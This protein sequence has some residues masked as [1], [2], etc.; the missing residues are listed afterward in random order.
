M[1]IIKASRGRITGHFGDKNVPGANVPSHLG[2]DL[3]HGDGTDDDLRI[4]AP[5]DGIV[6]AAGP[7]GSYGNRIIIDHGEGWTSLLAH[8][9]RILVAVGAKVTRGDLRRA[10]DQIAVMGSTGGNWAVHCHQELRFNGVPVNPEDYLTTTTAGGTAQ[11]GEDGLSQAEVEQI[12]EHIDTKF[13]QFIKNQHE[14]LA[15]RVEEVGTIPKP[16]GGSVPLAAAVAGIEA[17][18][19]A[20]LNNSRDIAAALKVEG[21]E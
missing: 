20:T 15:K 17:A 13:G 1:Q 2:M 3:G 16:D 6:T 19:Y 12:K 4:V 8:N 10:R 5:A 11:N 9:A 14:P 7:Y 18:S 21:I